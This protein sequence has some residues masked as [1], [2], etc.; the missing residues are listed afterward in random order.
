M[1]RFWPHILAAVTF[2]GVAG[3]LLIAVVKDQPDPPVREAS[4]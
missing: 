2:L 4:P 3:A 1:R